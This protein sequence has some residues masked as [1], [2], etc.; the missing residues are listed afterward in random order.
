MSVRCKIR[1]GIRRQ[2]M[3][4]TSGR[5]GRRKKGCG[6]EREEGEGSNTQS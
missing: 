1:E 4:E 2:E 6:K 5:I 3:L